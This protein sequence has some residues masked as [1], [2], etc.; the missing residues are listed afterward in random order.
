MG[1]ATARVVGRGA[2]AE[3]A[4]LPPTPHTLPAPRARAV[5]AAVL[6]LFASVPA[7]VFPKGKAGPTEG[8]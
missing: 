1:P 5:A 8:L 3:A 6:V 4:F 7:S 2:S